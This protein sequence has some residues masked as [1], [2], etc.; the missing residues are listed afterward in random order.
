MVVVMCFVSS[1]NITGKDNRWAFY[2]P[3]I[4]HFKKN[5]PQGEDVYS[6]GFRAGC[7]DGISVS[8]YG[9]HR[10]HEWSLHGFKQNYDVDRALSDTSYKGAYNEGYFYCGTAANSIIGF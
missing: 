6:S 1:C 3:R 5:I 4:W 7:N 10:L 2:T 8:G 9:G